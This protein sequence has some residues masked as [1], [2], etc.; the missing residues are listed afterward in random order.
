MVRLDGLVEVRHIVIADGEA[1]REDQ[2]V[3][4]LGP[5]QDWG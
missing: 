3:S 2:G 4:E 5:L 1:A